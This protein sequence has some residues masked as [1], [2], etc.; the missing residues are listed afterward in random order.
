MQS[1][2]FNF[3]K[4]NNKFLNKT[5]IKQLNDKEKEEGRE[6]LPEL[7]ESF[8]KDLLSTFKH[9]SSTGT[10]VCVCIFVYVNVCVC[11]LFQIM[12]MLIVLGLPSLIFKSLN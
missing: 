6:K 1:I 9:C 10:Y 2:F 12:S 7:Q 11:V 4:L 3:K 5:T 8:R